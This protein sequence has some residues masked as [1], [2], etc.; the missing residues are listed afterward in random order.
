LP[1]TYS[2]LTRM[3]LRRARIYVREEWKFLTTVLWKRPWKTRWI[4]IMDSFFTN[5]RFPMIYVTLGMLVTLAMSDSLTLLRVL[6]AIGMMS[7]F[8]M[9][10]Y[11]RSE[12]SFDFVYGIA[13]AYF[14]FFALFWIFPYAVLT[15][16]A[17]SWMTR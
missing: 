6:A 5:M 12:K 14:A 8:Y 9:L 1:E 11:L 3:F 4:S 17:R 15:V 2:K 13:Y 16:R 7:T 10:Y